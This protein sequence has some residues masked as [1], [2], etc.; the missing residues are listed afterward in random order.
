VPGIDIEPA[1]EAMAGLVDDGLV[2]FIG[3]SNFD[4][5]QIEACRR[6]RPVDALQPNFSMLFQPLSELI[7]W[8]GEQ[9][10]G[11]IS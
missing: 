5:D 3:V 7:A 1:W 2:R 4:R 6:V 8:C 10:I 11:V 9:G